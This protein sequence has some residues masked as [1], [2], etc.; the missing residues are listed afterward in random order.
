MVKD[1]G[2][3]KLQEPEYITYELNG[4]KVT[5]RKSGFNSKA[6]EENP[7]YE[8]VRQNS[9][10]FGRCSKA[11]KLI[12]STLAP[13]I[14]DI[15]DKYFYQKFAKFITQIKNLDTK[16]V[17]GERKV[18]NGWN[19]KESQEQIEQFSFG[20][21]PPVASHLKK[22]DSLF[23]K[24]LGISGRTRAKQIQLITLKPDFDTITMLHHVQEFDVTKSGV[25]EFNAPYDDSE[26]L[27]YFVILRN[28]DKVYNAGFITYP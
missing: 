22:L 26:F 3:N 19:L 4:M 23:T 18:E 20:V 27:M 24:P 28:E 1:E 15:G 17:K 16:N 7:K 25:Y 12:R 2:H 21:I 10:E 6:F 14:G 9:S 13:Y 5:R 11:G 8:K